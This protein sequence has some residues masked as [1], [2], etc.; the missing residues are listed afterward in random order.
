[1]EVATRKW[2]IPYSMWIKLI[3]ARRSLRDYRLR[4]VIDFRRWMAYI[5]NGERID[6]IIP[7]G[8]G[9]FIIPKRGPPTPRVKSKLAPFSK[10]SCI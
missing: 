6:L 3:L 8:K 10:T 5:R 9:I 7:S 1:M 4:I 2:G